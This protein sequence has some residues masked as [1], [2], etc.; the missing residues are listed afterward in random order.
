MLTNGQIRKEREAHRELLTAVERH[1]RNWLISGLTISVGGTKSLDELMTVSVEREYGNI[2]LRFRSEFVLSEVY[3][4]LWVSDG[5]SKSIMIT[6][7]NVNLGK[8]TGSYLTISGQQTYFDEPKPVVKNIEPQFEASDE[9]KP[10]EDD[11][12]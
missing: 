11:E 2:Y 12:E 3:T 10:V 6:G 1:V 8:P 9:V 4:G 5:E 7:S